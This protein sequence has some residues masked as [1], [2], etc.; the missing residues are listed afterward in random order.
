MSVYVESGGIV[1]NQKLPEHSRVTFRL[2]DDPGEAVTVWE[3]NGQLHVGGSSG[4]LAVR[5]VARNHWVLEAV[6]LPE[7]GSV[8]P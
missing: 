3:V 1:P 4:R 7:P 8:M 5:Q 2:R 6:T